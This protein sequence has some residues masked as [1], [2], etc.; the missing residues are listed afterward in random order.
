MTML[1]LLSLPL[2]TLAFTGSSPALAR[3]VKS[4]TPKDMFLEAKLSP[5]LPNLDVGFAAP[6][7]YAK[8][9]NGSSM[10]LGEVELDYQVFQ[11]FGTIA[12]GISAGYAE[13][14]AK[15]LEKKD[16]GT[17]SGESTGL[18][19]VPLKALIVY[20]F[21]LLWLRWSVPLVP[22]VKG[23]LVFMPW[24]VTKGPAVEVVDGLSAAGTKAGLAG[25]L[26]LSLTLDFLDRRLAAD[27]DSS[28]GV[29]HSYLFAEFTTQNLQL[30]EFARSAK[31]LN[32]SSNHWM[33]G[34]GFEF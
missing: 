17:R 30:F 3:E 1:R 12:V 27:F 9:F 33:F 26:G 32:F 11:K 15:A 4:Q 8:T 20:R 14:F 2:L 34:I 7:P 13:K 23:A 5:W 31:P 24:W 18:R 22:Y 28:M 6:G 21:D 10:L 19:V 25:V 29:N 16:T